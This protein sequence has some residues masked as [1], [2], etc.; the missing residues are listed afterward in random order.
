MGSFCHG[1]GKSRPA[2]AGQAFT[3]SLPPGG[4]EAVLRPHGLR[5]SAPASP[6]YR[7]DPKAHTH[8]LCEASRSLSSSAQA[9]GGGAPR[10]P[11][12]PQALSHWAARRAAPRDV[13]APPPPTE[14]S[15]SGVH[16]D[17]CGVVGSGG[18]GAGALQGEL[19]RSSGSRPHRALRGATGPGRGWLR[20]APTPAFPAGGARGETRAEREPRVSFGAGRETGA[21]R[22]G[23]GA[24]DAPERG[25]VANRGGEAAVGDLGPSASGNWGAREAEQTGGWN[26][27][28]EFAPVGA[29]CPGS[30]GEGNMKSSP[31]SPVCPLSVR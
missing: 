22:R 10:S 8:R 17:R 19:E 31:F 29:R 1:E 16:G 11:A 15:A 21:G 30:R 5:T 12:P 6:G 18:D 9:L 14:D 26:R 28:R 23:E 2:S 25:R 13:A 7:E 4:P 3:V 20:S 24:L 27:V